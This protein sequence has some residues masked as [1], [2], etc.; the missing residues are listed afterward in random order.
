[1]GKIFIISGLSGS[2]KGTLVNLLRE[3]EEAMKQVVIITSYTTRER[4]N[5]TDDYNFVSKKEFKELIDNGK[6]LEWNEYQNNFYGTPLDDVQRV[7]AEGRTPLLEIDYHGYLSV[8]KIY[9][10][11]VEGVFVVTPDAA[12]LLERLVKRGTE[13][14]EKIIS[15]LQIASDELQYVNVYDHCLINDQ[16]DEAYQKFK[17]LVLTDLPGD[18]PV[19]IEVFRKEIAA[20]V[21]QLKEEEE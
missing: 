20:A 3:D 4:R 21:E 6:L 13:T 11:E 2:G 9:K 7:L 1:M 12:T 19:D 14:K 15:R 5:E 16:L 10:D 8:K 17:D 18:P